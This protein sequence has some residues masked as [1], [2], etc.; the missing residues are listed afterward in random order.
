MTA[1]MT[2]EERFDV[3]VSYLFQMYNAEAEGLEAMARFWRNEAES[4]GWTE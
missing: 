1:A 2:E 4:L 3:L